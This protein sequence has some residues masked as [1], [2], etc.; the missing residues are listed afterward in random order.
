M[1]D[2]FIQC[3]LILHQEGNLDIELTDI[4][5]SKF[6]LSN[7]LHNNLSQALKLDF[8]IKI[9]V[10]VVQKMDETFHCSHGRVFTAG[11]AL[12]CLALNSPSYK[13]L[14]LDDLLHIFPVIATLFFEAQSDNVPSQA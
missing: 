1:F 8:L 3:D 7:L 14:C 6:V 5:L 9:E 12:V 13:A 2:D 4:L 11:E 10:A